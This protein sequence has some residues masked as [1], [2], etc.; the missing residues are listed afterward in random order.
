VDGLAAHRL[1][2]DDRHRR[3]QHRRGLRPRDAAKL[4]YA[5]FD[6]SAF[7][8]AVSTDGT[9]SGT[10]TSSPAGIDCGSDCDETYPAGTE[11][12][13][14]ATAAIG[15]V[16]G[17][18]SGDCTGSGPCTVTLGEARSVTATFDEGGGSGFYTLTPCRL[19]DTRWPAGPSGAPS[20]PAS[21]TR[22][23]P[24]AG[25][26]GVPPTAEA[27]AV[28]VTVVNATNVGHFRLYPAG[29]DLPLTST[30]NFAA[31]VTRAN[32]AVIPLGTAGEVAVL[33]AMPAGSADFV[34]DVT[35]Y[36]E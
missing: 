4:V 8:L 33:C 2:R 10:V 36:F 28:N 11:V 22:V 5:T 19:A 3:H 7:V 6:P 14:T 30:I 34:L 20:L 1:G 25:L 29:A 24:V 31:S 15:S 35:G 26:C 13:L 12:T 23:F 32:N 16:F 21:T 9:G 27:V 17:G 18:W